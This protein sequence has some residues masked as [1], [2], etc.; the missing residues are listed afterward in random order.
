MEVVEVKG[1]STRFFHNWGNGSSFERCRDSSSGEGGVDDSG[2]EG[3]QRGEAGFDKLG[4]VQL[5]GGWFGFP[6]ELCD[7]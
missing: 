5:T 7:F 1:V 3:D 6:D 2:D 4:R